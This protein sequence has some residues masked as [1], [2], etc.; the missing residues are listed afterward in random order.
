MLLNECLR[1]EDRVSK[2]EQAGNERKT[3]RLQAE[4]VHC[5]ALVGPN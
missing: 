1:Y 2:Y 4:L 5:R 3:A